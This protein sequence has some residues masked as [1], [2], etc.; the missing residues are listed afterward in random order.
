MTEL[1][2]C[3]LFRPNNHTVSMRVT[4]TP[5]LVGGSSIGKI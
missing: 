2:V 4:C 3:E 1:N 5:D